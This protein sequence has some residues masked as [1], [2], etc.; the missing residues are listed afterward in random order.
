MTPTSQRHTN[1]DNIFSESTLTL[2]T[3][4]AANERFTKKSAQRTITKYISALYQPQVSN[5]IEQPK[6]NIK[7]NGIVCV[8]E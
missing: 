1:A 2:D 4:T 7:W 5:Q 8:S 6:G 3:S